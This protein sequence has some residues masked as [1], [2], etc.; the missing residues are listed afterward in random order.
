[1]QTCTVHL[2][3]SD[4]QT[5]AQPVEAS[6]LFEAAHKAHAACALFWWSDPA[7]DVVVEL[8]GKRWRVTRGQVLAWRQNQNG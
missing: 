2:T 3:G 7:A 4:K 8:E 1:M 6:S 5:H